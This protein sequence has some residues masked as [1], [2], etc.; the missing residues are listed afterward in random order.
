MNNLT[1]DSDARV[2][3]MFFSEAYFHIELVD[4]LQITAPIKDNADSDR[5]IRLVELGPTNNWDAE[6]SL[7]HLMPARP[8]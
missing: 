4:G 2:K 3:D 5:R 1:S 7:D 6:M 8:A